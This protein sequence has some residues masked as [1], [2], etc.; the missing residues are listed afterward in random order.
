MRKKYHY[1]REYVLGKLP[2]HSVR[3]ALR[4]GDLADLCAELMERITGDRCTLLTRP[5]GWCYLARET[6]D[7]RKM[8]G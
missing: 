5:R 1:E 6:P 2:K 4:R 8:R 7:G 3:G